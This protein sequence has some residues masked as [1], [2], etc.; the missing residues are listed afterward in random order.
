VTL[1]KASGCPDVI[2]AASAGLVSSLTGIEVR[3]EDGTVPARAV[4]TDEASAVLPRVR[5]AEEFG[6]AYP[7][8]PLFYV[9]DAE[10]KPLA[11]YVGTG[12]VAAAFKEIGGGK[13]VFVGAASATMSLLREIVRLGG[14]H[15][16]LESDDV[17]AAGNGIVAVHAASEGEKVLTLPQACTLKDALAGETVLRNGRQLRLLMKRGETK[18]LIHVARASRP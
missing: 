4:V 9:S 7:L 17:V 12:H 16:Y 2:G 14:A 8:S 15:V 18:I 3:E 13:S 11:N 10:A 6:R 1:C 5:V